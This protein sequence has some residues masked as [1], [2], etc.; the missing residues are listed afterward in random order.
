MQVFLSGCYISS[1]DPGPDAG[2]C[3][4]GQRFSGHKRAAD[5][6]IGARHFFQ[7]IPVNVLT[8]SGQL[9]EYLLPLLKGLIPYGFFQELIEALE[10]KGFHQISNLRA[11]V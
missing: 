6:L 3:P 8:I 2:G 11:G 1:H 10:M 5:Y 7:Q 4:A 9:E